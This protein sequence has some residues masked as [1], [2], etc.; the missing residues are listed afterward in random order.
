MFTVFPDGAKAALEMSWNGVEVSIILHFEKSSPTS[1]DFTN[2]AAE[3]AA[4]FADDLMPELTE[5]L[6][7]GEVVVYDL[8]AENAP[9][10]VNTDES[11]TQGT[12]VGDSVP[13]NTSPVI[14]HRT[15]ATGRSGRGRT[16]LPGISEAQ[17]SNGL[18]SS[19]LR[20]DLLTAWGTF[21]TGIEALGW[22]F[23]IAQRFSG[24]S[25][26]TTGIMREVVTE[27]LKLQ[28]GTQRRRQVQSAT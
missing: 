23:V 8:S 28:L 17:E 22:A 10:Y 18:L 25:Q 27:I 13:N 9:K 7:M 16:Y 19:G 6:F 5:E 24:G 15:E 3:V 2:L 4:G 20:D 14:S 1:T 26:L 21:I 12:L 11:G